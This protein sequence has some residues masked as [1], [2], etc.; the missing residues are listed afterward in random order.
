MFALM[1]EQMLS[2]DGLV[3]IVVQKASQPAIFYCETPE[4]D[5]WHV[6]C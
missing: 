3:I 4:I 1:L 5:L 2:L 6:L